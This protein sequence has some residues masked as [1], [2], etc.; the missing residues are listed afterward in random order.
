MLG[1][2]SL[3]FH[4]HLYS[5]Y[6]DDVTVFGDYDYSSYLTVRYWALDAGIIDLDTNTDYYYLY[7]GEELNTFGDTWVWSFTAAYTALYEWEGYEGV[8]FLLYSNNAF[9]RVLESFALL[10]LASLYF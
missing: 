2:Y 4:V 9:Y 6:Y 5:F 1:D 3:C 10:G 8:F 7:E